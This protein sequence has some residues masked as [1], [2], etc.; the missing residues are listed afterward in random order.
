MSTTTERPVLIPCELGFSL[1]SLYAVVDR[2]DDTGAAMIAEVTREA[3]DGV[4]RPD[5]AAT[6]LLDLRRD[7]A[8]V[9]EIETTMEPVF[10]YFTQVATAADC[11]REAIAAE[12]DP[13]AFEACLADFREAL[14]GTRQR[15]IEI[16]RLWSGNGASIPALREADLPR[17][18]WERR[19]FGPET[20]E[21]AIV[22]T[23]GGEHLHAAKISRLVAEVRAL[24]GVR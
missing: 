10:R 21:T 13:E 6:A 22:R 11:L 15:D 4:Y 9:L 19:G 18:E 2:L 16:A 20:V 23:G 5:A 17:G 8:E 1:M 24:D 7:F 3:R 12:R 14:F